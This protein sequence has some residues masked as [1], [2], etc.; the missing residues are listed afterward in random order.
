MIIEN[1]IFKRWLIAGIL[2][3]IQGCAGATL[4]PFVEKPYF[5]SPPAQLS[6][7]DQE[8]FDRALFRQT[9][10]RLQPAIKVWGQF[11]EKY[12]RSFEAHN[13]LGLVYFEDDQLDAAVIELERALS[14]EPSETK[15]KKNLVRA[16]NFKALLYREA[17]D[18]N[19]AV[20]TLKR[21]QEISTPEEKEKVGY[22]IEKYEDKA[23]E[24][25]KR[26]NTLEA[27]QGFL[28]RYPKSSKNS[29]E[30]RTKIEGLKRREVVYSEKKPEGG[31]NSMSSLK[32]MKPEEVEAGEAMLEGSLME[33]GNKE[34][35]AD[36]TSTMKDAVKKE[37][38]SLAD[39]TS[40]MKD[41]VK[42]EKE[43]LAGV[44]SKIKSDSEKKME[45]AMTGLK[46]PVGEGLGT[47]GKVEMAD[48]TPSIPKPLDNGFIPVQP[49]EV[50]L[51]GEQK[52]EIATQPNPKPATGVD[53]FSNPEPEIL[54][55]A[56]GTLS[57]KKMDSP[58]VLA[59]AP[60]KKVKIVTSKDPLR[61]RAGPRSDS[62][63][64]ATVAKG[65]LVPFVKEENGWYKIEFSAG[66][67][68]WVSKKYALMVE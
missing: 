52:I 6:K 13:N 29:D 48:K 26:I 16:L 41:E 23:F 21:V 45:S 36:V 49:L 47:V 33:E 37:E 53:P 11:L 65:S 5:A 27:Y 40:T 19:R 35:M 44:A 12:P 3:V 51:S 55:P 54:K 9:N 68:G 24:Q 17:N 1:K 28:I 59:E 62:K 63:V 14:L 10:N 38:E 4:N 60:N 56:Q 58:E 42:K 25:A 20:D 61:I 2:I 50:P 7:A 66:Q 8:L 67:M 18:Y 15:I 30:A 64:L 32:V 22:R 39:A 57:P 34:N 31:V 43:N 46:E